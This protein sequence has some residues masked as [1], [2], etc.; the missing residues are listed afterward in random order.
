MKKLDYKSINDSELLYLVR[1]GNEEAY[2]LIINKYKYIIIHILNETVKNIELVGM[3]KIDLYQE[4]LMGLLTAIKNFDDKK[5]VSFYTFAVR[6]VK[7]HIYG[8]LR[9]LNRKKSTVL[10]S[11]YSLDK[12]LYENN[13][14]SLYEIIKDE[15]SNPNKVFVDVECEKETIE[16]LYEYCSKGEASIL[17][18]RLM[19]LSNNEI[20]K[21]LDKDKKQI[22]NA[23]FRIGKKYKELLAKED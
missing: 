18:Y 3:E 10:N 22:E 5:D 20:S 12:L 11:S 4:G 21:L 23:L 17:R 9:L 8:S 15:S 16:S 13:D 6:C 2:E 14:I 1:E 7:N 19:G